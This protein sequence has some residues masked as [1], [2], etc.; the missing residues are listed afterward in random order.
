[1]EGTG[2]VDR[3]EISGEE[4]LKMEKKGILVVSFGTSHL[5]TMAKTIQVM[6]EQIAEAF[7]GYTVYRAFTS[8]MILNKLERTE[9]KKYDNVR[10]AL[11]RMKQDGITRVIVQPT[12]IINGIENEKMLFLNLLQHFHILSTALKMKKCWRRFKN[13]RRLLKK[14]WWE[15]HFCLNRMII[16]RQCMQ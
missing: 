7:P 1:M 4:G 5:D 12:H 9:H 6:E 11:E 3:I 8:Q 13:M 10:Q 15:N 2:A 14:S 16:K